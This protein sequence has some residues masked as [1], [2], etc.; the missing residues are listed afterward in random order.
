[1]GKP[2]TEQI[3]EAIIHSAQ[4]GESN[5]DFDARIG[6]L[7]RLSDEELAA[8][9]IYPNGEPPSAANPIDV[10][11]ARDDA[12]DAAPTEPELGPHSDPDPL[13]F[14]PAGV[15]YRHDGWTAERQRTF[16]AALAETGCVSEACGEVGITARSA[17]RLRE[18]SAG[19][20][21]RSAWDHA[22]SLA[23]VRL[24]A[25]AWE[26]AVHGTPD[27]IYK[28]GVLVAERRRPS[29]KLLMWLLAHHNPVG[30]GWAAKPPGKA[31]DVSFFPVRYARTEL[32]GCLAEFADVPP[33]DCP[34]EIVPSD[35][36]LDLN[37]E[38]AA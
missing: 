6:E 7:S 18:H 4:V 2:S 31:P 20:A 36:Y 10:T 19:A 27:R 12:P 33:A 1:M 11:A 28:D 30:Y 32:P 5:A 25:I 34:A 24:T 35:D 29:D 22:Q 16:I 21:F 9:G 14:K 8:M 3:A 23:S 13:F 26:R 17:Y 38:P 15:R 37:D